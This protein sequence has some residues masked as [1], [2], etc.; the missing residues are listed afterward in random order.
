MSQ[1]GRLGHPLPG[2]WAGGRLVAVAVNWLPTR[3]EKGE[4]GLP[5]RHTER[6]PVLSD[7]RLT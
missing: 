7:R 5:A 1:L 6:S 4:E 3:C 2:A